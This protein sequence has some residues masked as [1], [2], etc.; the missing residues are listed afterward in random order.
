MVQWAGCSLVLDR[1]LDWL[2]TDNPLQSHALHQPRDS[3]AGDVKPF[4]LH[5]SPNRAHA[6]DHEVLGENPGSLGLQ[7]HIPSRA[8]R[9]LLRVGPLGDMIVK[10]GWGDRQNAAD[11]LDPMHTAMILDE[12]DHSL[13]GRPSSA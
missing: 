13:N 1:G 9:E 7:C 10:G 6:I 8:Q 4:A 5:L 11:R 3:A 12:T 2:S